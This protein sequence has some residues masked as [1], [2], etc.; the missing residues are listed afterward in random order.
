M[1]IAHYVLSSI[2]HDLRSPLNAVIGFSRI[3]IKG[4]DGPLSDMQLAD[5]EAIYTN[6]QMMLEMVNEI[7]DLGK[8]EAGTL[9]PGDAQVYLEPVIEKLIT[10]VEP[11]AGDIQIVSE[12]GDLL[13]S[14]QAEGAHIEQLL[15]DLVNVAMHCIESGRITIK[16]ESDGQTTTV[17]ITALAS[18]ELAPNAAHVLQAFE[19]AGRSAEHRVDILSLK[20]LVC[21][22]RVALYDGTL[23]IATPSDAEMTMTIQ[24]PTT[25]RQT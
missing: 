7:I 8:T 3:M 12:P 18:N 6:G 19:T 14:V 11:Q 4:L 9:A 22:K 15:T 17:Q 16:T 25:R 21:Q 13:I 2:A 10:Q 23:A 1:P 20:L 24:M 5:L